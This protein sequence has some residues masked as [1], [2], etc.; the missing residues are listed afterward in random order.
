[1]PPYMEQISYEPGTPSVEAVYSRAKRLFSY[2]FL[3]AEM[4]MGRAFL[5]I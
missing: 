5:R 1:M 3:F 2:G 4:R